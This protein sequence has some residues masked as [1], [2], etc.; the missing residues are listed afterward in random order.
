VTPRFT[1][2][3]DDS[4]ELD[5]VYLDRLRVLCRSAPSAGGDYVTFQGTS[6]AAP[7]VAGVAALVGAA[8]PAASDVEIV[9]AIEDGGAPLASLTGNTVSGRTADADG[10]IAAALALPATAPVPP[11]VVAPRTAR[12]A[13]PAKPDLSRARGTIRVSRGGVFRYPFR[14]AP[15]LTGRAVFRTRRKAVVSHRAHLT[16]ARRYFSVAPSGRASVWVKLTKRQLR[17]L[18]R[19]RRL[20][21]RATVTVENDAS[22]SATATKRLTLKPPKPR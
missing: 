20:L 6:M 14:A 15:R 18:K 4:I 9:Q 8:D 17:I 7:H 10:A 12:V 16:I 22:L 2:L 5:G 3:A 19:N 1:L 13:R 11:T 21:L